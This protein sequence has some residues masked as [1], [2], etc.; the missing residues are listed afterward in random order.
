VRN[1]PIIF[2]D[3]SGH[4]W[5][6]AA[7]MR[8]TAWGE[9][10]CDIWDMAI[11]I[12]NHPDALPSERALAAGYLAVDMGAHACVALCM[13]LAAGAEYVMGTATAAC[14]D[15]D[16]TNEARAGVAAGRQVANGSTGFTPHTVNTLSAGGANGVSQFT[17]T[18]GDYNRSTGFTFGS[19]WQDLLARTNPNDAFVSRGSSGIVNGLM[20]VNRGQTYTITA[21]EGRNG[22]GTALFKAAINDSIA[23]GYGGAIRL[24]PA[25]TPTAL[26][27]YQKFT[28]YTIGADGFW[29]WSPEAAQALVNGG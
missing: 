6:F 20:T 28:G 26:A 9:T 19:Y 5:G 10:R 29:Y 21:L 17:S 8:D 11:D 15:G 27:F 2:N 16:C 12:V 25:Q 18:I 13:P 1:N 14:G 4:C 23:R 24:D 7:D 22:G 3:P